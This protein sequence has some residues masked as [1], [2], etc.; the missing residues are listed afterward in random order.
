[1]GPRTCTHPHIYDFYCVCI[2]LYH[3]Y[4]IDPARRQSTMIERIFSLI[5]KTRWKLGVLIDF[6]GTG[7]FYS[8]LQHWLK[9]SQSFFLIRI[10]LNSAYSFSKN[11]WISFQLLSKL[12]IRIMFCLNLSF[13]EIF[14]KPEPFKSFNLRRFGKFKCFFWTSKLCR[15]PS[16]QGHISIQTQQVLNRIKRMIKHHTCHHWETTQPGLYVKAQMIF[17]N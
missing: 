5:D 17:V 2:S 9:L 8:S 11:I 15:T 4:F 14:W 16:E 6:L 3:S 1:M 7:L 12:C 10:C 13:I